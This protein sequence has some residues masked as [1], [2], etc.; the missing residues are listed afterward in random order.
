[1]NKKSF[2]HA[3]WQHSGNAL[4]QDG[5]AGKERERLKGISQEQQKSLKKKQL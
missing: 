5:S 1:M 3:V 2:S 4:Y